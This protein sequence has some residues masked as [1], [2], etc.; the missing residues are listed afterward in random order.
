MS[1]RK[2][3]RPF[4]RFSSSQAVFS[5]SALA[6]LACLSSKVQNRSALSSSAQ[7]TCKLSRV[8][9]PSLG[10]W[11]RA[12]SAQRSKANSGNAVGR[13]RPAAWSDAS[14]ASNCSDFSAVRFPQ[15]CCLARAWAHS[16]RCRA[17]NTRDETSRMRRRASGECSSRTYRETMKL[18][19]A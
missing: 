15:N 10:P 4:V 7:A 8:R 1:R 2:R 6:S 11:C 5:P 18:E 13:Q 12:S 14:W 9:T 16:A 17:V 19:S 3:S